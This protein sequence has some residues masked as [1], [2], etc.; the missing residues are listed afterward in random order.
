LDVV[1][2][3][4]ERKIAAPAEEVFDWLADSSN[5]ES[6][7]LVLRERRV[8]D[9]EQALYGVGAVREITALGAWFRE[10]VTLY[11]R[12]REFRYVI[13][14]SLPRLEHDGGSIVLEQ[15]D[16]Y[17][18]VVWTTSYAVPAAWGGAPVAR[19]IEVPLR[20]S[21]TGLLKAAE[22]AL[23]RPRAGV[24]AGAAEDRPRPGT[25]APFALMNRAVNPAVRA[26][27]RSPLHPLLSGRLALI[28]YTGRRSGRRYT[29]P[30]LYEREAD[31]VRIPV[32]WPARKRWWRNLREEGS[33]ELVLRGRRVPGRALASERDGRVRVEVG[34]GRASASPSSPPVPSSPHV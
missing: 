3:A 13:E 1:T 16:G 15:L 12:P 19:A 27:L 33:V 18:R 28:T 32:E 17:T 31:T 23:T 6:S 7:P 2:F 8:R 25:H 29:I 4:V 22:R 21:F 20:W 10:R 34:L 30:V 5:Y 14:K 24:A 26:I 11:E 9:G